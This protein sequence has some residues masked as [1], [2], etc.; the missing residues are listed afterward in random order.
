MSWRFPKTKHKAYGAIDVQSF[1]ENIREFSEE[2]SGELNEHN[3]LEGC[4]DDNQR[5]TCFEAGAA[6]D[7]YRTGKY[8]TVTT[9]TDL[10]TDPN[11]DIKL[12]AAGSAPST[13]ITGET[14]LFPS[15]FGAT[16]GGTDPTTI[17]ASVKPT[18]WY[19]IPETSTWNTIDD[20]TITVKSDTSSQLWIL[21]SFQY[22][23]QID[24]LGTVCYDA[25]WGN[26][27][28]GDSQY[29]PATLGSQF[30]IKVNGSAIW[31][32]CLGSSE[33]GT[34]DPLDTRE[35]GLGQFYHS[36]DLLA[37]LANP[38]NGTGTGRAKSP[39]VPYATP[40]IYGLR[41]PC[42]TDTLVSLPP[43]T[44]K[45]EVAAKTMWPAWFT[46]TWGASGT[47]SPN[48]RQFITVR[49]LI[50]LNMKR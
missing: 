34:Q 7:M 33:A 45:I 10:T 2:I 23:T 37:W 26:H 38:T 21:A 27:N 13:F 39:G 3:F 31:E 4:F 36:S 1:N 5:G 28:L 20:M 50:V 46:E 9:S 43:G 40:G 19:E 47:A 48:A 44:H 15:L 12:A 41:V 11:Q 25:S 49:E 18:G 22:Q 24:G 42:S 32:S 30:V 8:A 35:T 6:I 14:C 16:A 17:T 29:L